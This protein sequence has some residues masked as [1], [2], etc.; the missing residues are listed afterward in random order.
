[1]RNTRC[2]QQ[3]LLA[4]VALA[5][6]GRA[7]ADGAFFYCSS[8]TA[9]G[10]YFS[11]VF[12][13]DPSQQF[14]YASAFAGYLDANGVPSSAYGGAVCYPEH[15]RAA[16]EN[17]LSW[18]AR[19]SPGFV[20][21]H[22]TEWPADSNNQ[23]PQYPDEDSYDLD[24][25]S[26]GRSGFLCSFNPRTREPERFFDE[27]FDRHPPCPTEAWG[28]YF[29]G[30]KKERLRQLIEARSL[31]MDRF[32][33]AENPVN[34][35]APWRNNAIAFACRDGSGEIKKAIVWDVDFLRRL[36]RQA[37]TEWASVAVLAHEIAHHV[38][39]D[40]VQDRIPAP[41]R[42]E[43]ELHADKWAGFALAQLGVGRD[44]AVAVFR[45]L[46]DGGE[47]HPP[48]R[49]RVEWAGSG[50]DASPSR[51]GQRRPPTVPGPGPVDRRPTQTPNS[52]G[53][54]VTAYG[55]CPLA[56]QYPPRSPCYCPSA[57]GPIWGQVQ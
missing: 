37:G 52:V 12:R 2:L 19:A 25:H 13:G 11:E 23:N 18:A 33:A 35:Q 39:S 3:L 28:V 41:E 15:N 1:M 53:Y 34:I 48:A 27:F 29:T 5:I 40:T 17:S 57:Y 21:V 49:Q 55:V 6:S 14:A 10:T 4:M 24:D 46:G 22:L 31:R 43:Q 36:D 38:N 32:I 54:C 47:T 8:V 51:P 16:A 26:A 7:T 9:Q 30:D 45:L 42:R 50:W 20:P 56:E 44:E